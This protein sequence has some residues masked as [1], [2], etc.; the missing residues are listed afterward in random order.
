MFFV[1][2][3]LDYVNKPPPG[4]E[5]SD[6]KKAHEDGWQHYL[7][8][9]SSAPVQDFGRAEYPLDNVYRH[10]RKVLFQNEVKYMVA[11]FSSLA[12]LAY[13]Y[14]SC[15]DNPVD[16]IMASPDAFLFDVDKVILNMDFKEQTFSWLKKSDCEETLNCRSSQMF[17]DAQLLLG[18]SFLPTFPLLLRTAHPATIRDALNWVNR[19]PLLQLFEQYR[20]DPSIKAMSYADRYKKAALT[21]RHHVV[22]TKDG[23]VQPLDFD[24]A[25]GD[26]HAFVGQRLPDELFFYIS[27]GLLGPQVPN[28]LTSGEIHLNLPGGVLD[29]EPFRKFVID[30]LNPLRHQSLKL[31]AESLNYYFQH[32]EIVYRTWDGRDT[33][34]MNTNIREIAPLKEKVNEWRVRESTIVPPKGCRPYTFSSCLRA[35]KDS[36]FAAKS[37][38]S[39]KDRLSQGPLKSQNEIIANIYW[40]FLHIRGYVNDKHQ[41]TKWGEILEATL[42]GAEGGLKREDQAIL[43]VELLRA[44]QLNTS[45][46]VG[47]PVSPQDKAYQHKTN[48]NL[49]SK[50]GCIGRL[51]HDPVGYVGPLDRSLYTFACEITALRQSLRDLVEVIMVSMFLNGD[52]TRDR[53]DWF[54]LPHKIPFVADNGAGLGICVKSYLDEL[55]LLD[56]KVD[57]EAKEEVKSQ[58]G[59]YK[60]FTKAEN[61]TIHKSL[62]SAFKLF[63]AVTKGLKA[64]KDVKESTIFNEAQQWLTSRR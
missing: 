10:M 33:S 62:D 20:D 56:D 44:G 39:R 34:N 55:N 38:I 60:W 59:K 27:R 63:D 48:T 2:N 25:P 24:H 53:H 21:I 36:S 14:N 32:R 35:L 40:R 3:G 26:V 54:E 18:S 42:S 16:A 13:L 52:I 6:S 41:L 12:F 22:M 64:G 9:D 43:A 37:V 8:G 15:E 11:P 45:S 5:S 57:Q 19:A 23:H 49:L 46:V 1:F 28:W 7:A 61:G 31:L 47:T 4:S 17:K 51:K 50:I 30:D 29:C 58:T